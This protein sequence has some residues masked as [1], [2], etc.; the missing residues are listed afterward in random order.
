MSMEDEMNVEEDCIGSRKVRAAAA[1]VA[2]LMR[3]LKPKRKGPI[4]KGKK[5]GKVGSNALRSNPSTSSL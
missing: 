3:T 4:D 5:Q 1:G 2:K